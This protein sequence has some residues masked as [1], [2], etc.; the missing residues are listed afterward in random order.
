MKNCFN[1]AA[2]IGVI[3]ILSLAG[4]PQPNT[5]DPFVPV[6][7]ITGVPSTAEVGTP[8]TL[9][10]TVEP[11]NAT[12]QNISWS[13][14]N[15]GST[16]AVIS[17]DVL[18]AAAAGTVL[19]RA[20]VPNGL[21]SG[22]YTRD[23]SITVSGGVGGTLTINGLPSGGT[24]A[25]YVFSSGTDISTYNGIT[26]AYTNGSYQAVGATLGSDGTFTL[27]T[28]S[29]GSQGGGFTGDGSYP[30]LLLNSGGS[31]TDTGNP[32]YSQ[33]AVTFSNGAATVSY[34]SFSAVV[35]GD[36]TGDGATLTI[37]GLPSGATRAVY[38]FSP[39]TNIST[40]EGITAAYMNGSYQAVG[41]TLG[42]D[43]AFTLYTWS[44]GSQGGGFTGDGGRP[45]LL[46]NSAGSV[47]DTSNPMYSYAVAYF[48]NGTATVP[49]EN[50]QA[51]VS[52]GGGGGT[53]TITGLPSG[54]TRAV[55]VF[56]SGT[57]ISTYNAITAAYVNGSYQAVGAALGSDGVFTLYTW[58][59]GSQGGGFTGDGSYP[60]LLLNSGGSITDTGN[61]MYSQAV[62]TFSNGAGTVSYG[63][64]SA[65]VSGG[66]DTTVSV[67][68]LDGLITAPVVGAAPDTT[69]IDE[70]QYTGSIAWQSSGGASHTG[71]FAATAV[72]KAVL[73]LTAKDGW[74][75]DGVAANSF[76]Y[77]GATAVVNDADSG[78]V[79]ITFPETL[80]PV[81]EFDL[82]GLLD[83]P[84]KGGWTTVWS[85]NRNQYQ[86]SVVWQNEDG[87][88]FTGIFASFAVYKAVVTLTARTGWTFSGIAANSFTCTGAAAAN[89]AGSGTVTITFPRTAA[90]PV[91]EFDLTGHVTAPVNRA[92]PVTTPV[93]TNQY[94]G[95]IAWEAADGTALAGSFEPL[96]IYQAVL[97]LTAKDGW[98]FDG[99]WMNQ[100]TCTGA[101]VSND[102]DSGT[103][104]M[105]FPAT[106]G[107]PNT[108]IPPPIGNP[109]VK[110]YLNG[111]SAPLT[112]NGTTPITAGTGTYTVSVDP[113]HTSIVWYLNGTLQTQASGKTSI[114]LSRR[115]AG[116]YLV[117]V[118]T[119]AEA[120]KNS[121]AHTFTVQ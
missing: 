98:T 15:P 62:V 33:A 37:T 53:L 5:G 112:H 66:G 57:D 102:A 58:S 109:S 84:T 21:A 45:V 91:N 114:T 39:D 92:T 101:T 88:D 6:A 1:A 3:L 59:G 104:T 18:T 50:F 49:Y 56:G 76:T 75:F 26:A 42:S 71:A 44:G 2:S 86:G 11:A 70:A 74:T 90:E 97:T 61:P 64:F 105:V 17:G 41:A 89:D 23:F 30:V 100:F 27:Y 82:D 68:S 10:G 16:G 99:V 9:T 65:V 35:S 103:V 96:T 28:W 47:T 67:F 4:C 119:G 83:I 19:V 36:G 73:T 81:D 118:E 80:R 20:S 51:V 31:V 111:A 95:S 63:S 113:D 108:D 7:A 55:Y 121:G 22:P 48:S 32:M 38:V 116:A 52:G 77:T 43:G 34:G 94:T 107:D 25:V 69:A 106:K 12:N 54:G 24:R 93:N 14:N 87:T 13:V 120:S 117:T 72:Y 40:Y 8:L 46:L 115:T 79:T 78:T 85:I 110:L 60:V 29:G